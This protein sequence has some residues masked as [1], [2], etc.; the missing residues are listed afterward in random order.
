MK[1]SL[2]FFPFF[3]LS[4]S[5]CYVLLHPWGK[6]SSQHIAHLSCDL[7]AAAPLLDDSNKN[8][9]ENSQK[10]EDALIPSENQPDT[11]RVGLC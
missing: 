2:S 9:T 8:S 10:G 4:W 1:S 3:W 6:Q 5:G 7:S 11:S